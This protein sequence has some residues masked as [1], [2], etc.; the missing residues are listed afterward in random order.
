MTPPVA[1]AIA[2]VDSSGGAGIAADL[3]TFAAHGVLGASAVTA[4]TAQS[5]NAVRRIE[6]LAPDVVVEQIEAVLEDLPVVAVKTGLLA[7]TAVA[8][9]IA[10]LA[11]AG[12]LPNLVVDPVLASSSGTR[13]VDD[14]ALP[15]L[16]QRLFP[17]ARVVTPNTDEAA[18]LLGTT[19]TTIEDRRHAARA[20]GETGAVI[21][22][23]TGGSQRRRCVDVVWD[24]TRITELRAA[25]VPTSN[26]RG[27]G[28]SFASAI[29]A[30]L[31]L[32][33][34]PIDAV[35][36][37]KA[38]VHLALEG[39]RGWRLGTGAGPLDHFFDLDKEDTS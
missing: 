34:A 37:A 26:T 5:A 22:V 12:R 17:R 3:K 28:C 8:N 33:L 20:L 39:A 16:L 32:G 19:I 27:T 11:D 29:A 9:A 24:G 31:A 2:G 21:V 14:G 38:Y 4:V 13:L 36:A 35:A 10:E 23:V 1:L 7:R 25:A 30:R 6:P 15:V 18:A